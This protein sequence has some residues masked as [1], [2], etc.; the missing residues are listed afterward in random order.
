MLIIRSVLLMPVYLSL[1]VTVVCG[2]E[3]SSWTRYKV[4]G[5][6]FSIE[7]PTHPAMTTYKKHRWG[8]R[9][10]RTELQLGAYA[11]GVV[12]TINSLDDGDA[13][14]AFRAS[15]EE[16]TSNLGW[17]RLSEQ[18]LSVNGFPGK[19]YFSNHA[20]G[21]V[22][23]VFE[24]KNRVYRF[25]VFGAKAD[26]PR[27][28]Q[29]FSSLSLGKK[30][31]GSEV[32]DGPGVPF[33][34]TDQFASSNIDGSGT[35]FKGRDVDR[36]ALLVMKP[37]PLYT[38][39]ARKRRIT[40]TVVLKVIFSSDGSVRNIV[41]VSGLPGGLTERAIDAAR[42]LKFMPA[43]KEGKFVSIWMQLEYNFNLY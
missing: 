35:V 12:Y 27:V 17:D 14:E 2:Q 19:Q 11:D 8:I 21:G 37:E 20:L 6:E 10:D 22:V 24:M 30:V 43:V 40:G 18:K 39:D 7:L 4:K 15:I 38:E 16:I 32:S 1:L 13:S 9:K 41:T 36:K 28:K 29:F 34:P 25:A 42:K 31:T 33:K 3:S 26:D 5:E 23:Q